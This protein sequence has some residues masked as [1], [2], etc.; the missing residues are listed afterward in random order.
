MFFKKVVGY[1]GDEP[2]RSAQRTVIFHPA[3]GLFMGRLCV[4]DQLDPSSCAGADAHRTFLSPDLCGLL[5]CLLPG[6]N[7]FHADLLCGFPG[8]P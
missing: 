7:S 1:N 4:L 6:H 2:R 3:L 8:E 5:Y